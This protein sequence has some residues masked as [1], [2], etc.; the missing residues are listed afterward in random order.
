MAKIYV[1]SSWRN[2]YYSDVVNRLRE[3]GHEVYDF[4]NPPQ[5]TGGFHWSDS[6]RENMWYNSVVQDMI[7]KFSLLTT[8]THTHSYSDLD[9][10]IRTSVL[11][12][13]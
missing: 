6:I 10:N 7:C 8:Y 11:Q 12:L 9:R 4:R 3:A 5:G 2:Q 1:A 13:T